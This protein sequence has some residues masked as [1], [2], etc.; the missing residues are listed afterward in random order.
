M[1]SINLKGSK[2]TKKYE[3]S[4]RD[5]IREFQVHQH[6]NKEPQKKERSRKKEEEKRAEKYLEE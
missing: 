3:Q 6:I 1:R 5:P 2:T 4:L